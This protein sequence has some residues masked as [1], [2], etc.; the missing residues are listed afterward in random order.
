MVKAGVFDDV[1]PFFKLYDKPDNLAWHENRDPGTHNYLLDNRKAAY[2]FFSRHF[3][4]SP[5]EEDSSIG[6]EVKSYEDLVV[7]LPK[8][9]LTIVDLARKLAG[10]VN[11]ESLSTTASARDAERMQLEKIVRCKRTKVDR[12]WTV[13]ITKHHGIE[14]K[15]YLFS[16]ADG[17]TTNALWLK[18]IDVP[19]G[20]AATIILDDKGKG[21][22]SETVTDRVNRG[23]Q[24]LAADLPF[25]GDAWRGDES[26]ELEQIV[27][28]TG[29]R[30]L[31]IEAAHLIELGRWLKQ[32]GGTK[33][34]LETDGKRTQVAA[35]ITAA[36]EPLLFSE[37]KIRS[38]MPSLRYL[39]DKPVP[40]QEAVDLFCLDL[41]K[42]T[43][44]DR[45]ANLAAPTT[46]VNRASQ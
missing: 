11:R 1:L 34:R 45:L 18:P 35:L 17:L 23:E 28:T 27:A 12:L 46:V 25:Y 7:G 20:G 22:A 37:V 31:G 4:L 16:M 43:D 3:N 15:A 21:A 9:N 32:R 42:V 13:G 39:I 6:S 2:A 29:A 38:G 10:Q 8:D 14:T 24:V 5:I 33:I 19:D 44:L 40:F 41:Y 36:L 30:P 26:W